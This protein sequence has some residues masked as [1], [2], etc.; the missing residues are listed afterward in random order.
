VTVTDVQPDVNNPRIIYFT[1]DYTFASGDVIKISFPDNDPNDLIVA[2]DA[3][4]LEVFIQKPV[5]NRESIIHIIPGRI[6]AEDFSYQEGVQIENAQDVGG[7]QSLGF[8]DAGDFIE[9]EVDVISDGVYR[10]DYR[11]ASDAGSNGQI[12]LL[13]VDAFGNETSLQQIVFAPT[14]GWQTWETNSKTAM[15]EAGRQTIRVLIAQGSFNLNWIEF[16][17]LTSTD[18]L[19]EAIDFDIYPNPTDGEFF[20][21]GK[22]KNTQDVEIQIFDLLGRQVF[23]KKINNVQEVNERV[24]LSNWISGNYF[25]KIQTEDGQVFSKKIIKQ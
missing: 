9:Y 1:V 22:I 21:F 5:E 7:G 20:V 4:P 18:D 6:E 3:T 19:V 25:V 12:Q 16:S 15:L 17:D 24:E 14:G 11:T 10:V 23:S 13:S 8:L 2:T